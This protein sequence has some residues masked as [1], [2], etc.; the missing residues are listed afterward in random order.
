MLVLQG[1]ISTDTVVTIYREPQIRKIHIFT[2]RG[3][4]QDLKS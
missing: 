3:V 1:L 2:V 4:I